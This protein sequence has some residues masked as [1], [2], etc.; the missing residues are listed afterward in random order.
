MY[1]LMMKR[2]V[3]TL[4]KA[5]T[6]FTEDRLDAAEPLFTAARGVGDVMTLQQMSGNHGLQ[7]VTSRRAELAHAADASLESQ[8]VHMYTAVIHTVY[9]LL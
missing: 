1:E 4:H 7:R 8:C 2:V 6:A 3:S 9:L 5:W